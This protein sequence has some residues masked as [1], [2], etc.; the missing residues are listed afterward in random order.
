MTRRGTS[1]LELLIGLALAGLLAGGAAQLMLASGASFERNELR[2]D[3]AEWALRA[4][5][6]LQ[7]D[8]WR[9]DYDPA[10]KPVRSDT[11]LAFTAR[12]PGG[13]AESIGWRFDAA[14]GDL[15]R[16]VKGTLDRSFHLGRGARVRFGYVVPSYE[17]GQAVK[18]G[19]AGNRV[20]YALQ[21]FRTR[22]R[23]AQALAL[24][25]GVPLLTKISGNV[26]PFWNPAR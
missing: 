22:Y 5:A 2:V 14:T 4:Q 25:G 12:V 7:A 19:E 16:L 18:L 9:L 10:I 6:F 24:T 26:F 11:E 20:T 21:V 23:F 15:R 3:A 13:A 17:R 8:L 1:L